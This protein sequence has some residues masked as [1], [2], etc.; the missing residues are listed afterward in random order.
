MKSTADR[1]REAGMPPPRDDEMFIPLGST[2]ADAILHEVLVADARRLLRKTHKRT[3][4]N[5]PLPERVHDP[6]DP[7][8]LPEIDPAAYGPNSVPLDTPDTDT[9][10][11]TS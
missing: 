9:T 8:N 2:R 10:E 6:A 1:Y 3:V 5:T 11:E 4:V 7:T